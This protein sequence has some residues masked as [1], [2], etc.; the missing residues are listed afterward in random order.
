MT[1]CGGGG[2]VAIAAICGGDLGGITICGV[3]GGGITTILW[4]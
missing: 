4:L 3:S 2:V 1:A